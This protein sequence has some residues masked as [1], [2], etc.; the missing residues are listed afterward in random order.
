MDR[1]L[2]RR[3]LLAG[4][5]GLAGALAGCSFGGREPSDSD[6]GVTPASVPTVDTPDPESNVR[7]PGSGGGSYEPESSSAVLSVAH[8]NQRPDL[9]SGFAVMAEG[10]LA[11]EPDVELEIEERRG[12]LLSR[13]AIKQRARRGSPP[14]IWQSEP[15][16]ILRGL[17]DADLLMD[18]T[19]DVWRDY[20]VRRTYPHAVARTARPGG[21][22]VAVPWYGV[23]LNNLF[24]DRATVEAAGVDP[25]SVETTRG[26]LEVLGAVERET[27]ATPLALGLAQPWQIAQLFE[28]VLLARTGPVGIRQIRTGALADETAAAI[29]EA[30][31]T[32]AELAAFFPEDAGELDWMGAVERVREGRAAATVARGTAVTGQN[33]GLGLGDRNSD[34]GE[35][36]W[37]HTVFPGTEDCFQYTAQSFVGPVNNPS[38]SATRR[39]LRYCATASAQRRFS[40]V[41]GTVPLRIDIAP[42][43]LNTFTRGQYRDYRNA[44]AYV[45]SVAHG[46]AVPGPVFQQ[47]LT[48]LVEFAGTWNVEETADRLVAA[49]DR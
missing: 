7:E 32:V 21:T 41:A 24:Y 46:L 40:A 49:L 27:E 31:G 44:A 47:Y 38:P 2:S 1:E 11:G 36:S 13:Q 12:I 26:F 30:L 5:A 17:A 15:G 9:Q 6:L 29:T 42:E 22:H 18:I 48:A 23:R 14:S 10:F 33:T 34:P 4:T 39:W 3:G 35:R 20:R 43:T 19:D 37:V 25:T 16:G 28:T 8:W 45:P